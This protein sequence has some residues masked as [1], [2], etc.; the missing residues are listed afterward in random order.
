MK[1]YTQNRKAVVELPREVWA[2]GNGDERALV[3]STSYI[4]PYLG[5]YN[6]IDRAKEV[7]KEIFD[8]HRNG[9]NSYIMPEQ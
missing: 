8:Y 7:V 3:V 1:I 6:S 2:A 4:S 5:E 9:K